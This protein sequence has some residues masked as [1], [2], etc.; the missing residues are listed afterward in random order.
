L[1]F[2]FRPTA[3]DDLEWFEKY[4]GS[5]FPE[6]SNAA[7]VRF[8]QSKLSI[9]KYPSIGHEIGEGTLL[10]ELVIPRTLFSMV[11]YLDGQDIVLVQILDSRAQRP[12]E[13][14]A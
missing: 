11:Y 13:F 10:R 9:L 3:L 12:T 7:R 8:R 14:T 2:K 5:V 1:K 4:Y 6:G